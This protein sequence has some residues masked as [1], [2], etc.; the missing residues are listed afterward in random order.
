MLTNLRNSQFSELDRGA[1][2]GSPK[3]SRKRQWESRGAQQKPV[4]FAKVQGIA[5]GWEQARYH[6]SDIY[7]SCDW[8]VI[9]QVIGR[10]SCR[11][12]YQGSP[13]KTEPSAVLRDLYNKELAYTV[14]GAA[15][16]PEFLIRRAVYQEGHCTKSGS[17]AGY[18]PQL[19]ESG[20]LD[21]LG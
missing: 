16:L 4:E 21:F 2:V 13:R 18:G 10:K 9:K 3:K 1:N 15:R 7:I 12:L 5:W 8:V 14:V 6:K 11:P 17:T 20:L 19:I